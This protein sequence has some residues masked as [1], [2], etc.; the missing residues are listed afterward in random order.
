[1]ST[2]NGP[3][4]FAR[5]GAAPKSLVVLLHGR[6]SNGDDLIGL[7]DAIAS[8]FPDTAFF[9]PNAPVAL[10]GGAYQWFV[11]D[12]YESREVGLQE[13]A[14]VVNEF[15]DGLLK[16]YD[17]P[18]SKC[19]LIGFS[20]GTITSI[21]VAPRRADQLAGVVGFS[22]AMFSGASLA[23]EM[24]SKPPFILIHGD[25]DMVLDSK[26]TEIAA[27]RLEERGVPVSMHI[28]PGLA[29]SID[30]RGLSLAIEFLER[31]L[32]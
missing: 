17:I 18:S 24:Q 22:G 28:L 7:A 15:I 1:M 20:Q 27:K 32:E 3:S 29:H 25:D 19:A 6:G 12:G 11:V 9:S 5:S 8:H 26:E 31:A 16:K 14:P 30:H 2:L 10:G 21:H 13:S 4:R 23:D